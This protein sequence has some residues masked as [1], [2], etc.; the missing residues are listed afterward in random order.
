M[1]PQ[2]RQ[3]DF[4]YFVEIVYIGQVSGQRVAR[5]VTGGDNDRPMPPLR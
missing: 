2:V 5:F 4:T 1:I 3:E